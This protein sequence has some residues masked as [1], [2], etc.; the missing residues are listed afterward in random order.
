MF[1]IAV[2]VAAYMAGRMALAGVADLIGLRKIRQ[3]ERMD[4]RAEYQ[5][6]RGPDSL[7]W[8]EV[9]HVI[10]VPSYGE[11]LDVLRRTL[12]RLACSPL[13]RK[14]VIVV[15][16]MEGRDPYA[17]SD[18]DILQ[19]EFCKRFRLVIS[20]IH[21]QGLPGEIPAKSANEAWA[22]QYVMQEIVEQRGYPQKHIV[23]TSIDADSLLHPKYLE[24]LTCLF[25]TAPDRYTAFWQAPIR[26]HNNIWDIHPA[27]G[28]LQAS[29]SAWDL[30]YLAGWWW[31]GLP[32]STYSL[33]LQLISDVD[34][35]DTNVIADES[36]MF[37]KCNFRYNGKV[38]LHP[39]FLPFSGYAVAGDTFWEACRNR[40]QQTVRHAWGA[41]EIGYTLE[42][43]IARPIPLRRALG[44]LWSV[45]HDNLIA[46]AGWVIMTFGA[47]MPITFK[48][49]VLLHN[50]ASPQAILLQASLVTVA[51]AGVLF[52]Q[53]DMRLRPPRPRPWTAREVLM[54][55]MSFP[56]L[57]LLLLAL[58]A[59]PVIEA[60]TRMMLGIKLKFQVT[61]KV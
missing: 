24:S 15:L 13:A 10:I 37:V 12:S 16:A 32:I 9:R 22:A 5:R 34:Y 18:A 31:R 21:P 50:L 60:H 20:T 38:A 28:L 40:Y 58:L 49:E 44:L 48:P 19:A 8:D 25:A 61:R 35:W 57:T 17:D 39:I 52:W 56:L 43:M 47:Q 30:A 29:A 41:K 42:Q 11:D 54:T 59:I 7:R 26:Y 23:V 51:I 6:R 45:A 4:W 3:W 55:V 33:S 46:G 14:Q 1:N 36:H 2:L 27:L 53:V